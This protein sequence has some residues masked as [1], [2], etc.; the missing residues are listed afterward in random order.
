MCDCKQKT[1]R[2][3]V[4][5]LAEPD[6]LPKGAERIEARLTGYAMMLEGNAMRYRQVM[7]IEVQYLAPVKTGG[8]KSKKQKLSM[9]ANYC[10]FCGEKYDNEEVQ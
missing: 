3:L 1:E 2:R 7:E 9:A 4:E 8:L 6:Q 5:A 10:M